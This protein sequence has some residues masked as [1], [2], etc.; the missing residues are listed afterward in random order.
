MERGRPL[1]APSHK[2]TAPW[3][4][5]IGTCLGQVSQVTASQPQLAEEAHV[6]DIQRCAGKQDWGA[7]LGARISSPWGGCGNRR[8]EEGPGK[9][10]IGPSHVASPVCP[11]LALRTLCVQERTRAPH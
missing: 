7:P 4:V 6:R 2:C 10:T 1:V 3:D 5:R 11:G 9:R 8:E